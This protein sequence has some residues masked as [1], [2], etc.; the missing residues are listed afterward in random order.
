MECIDIK[1]RDEAP[2][3]IFG[4]GSLVE[5][6]SRRRTT[7]A[8]RDAWPVRVQGVGRGW[9]ARDDS[10]LTTTY[11]GAIDD[12]ASRCNGVIYRVSPVALAATD[13]AD[14]PKVERFRE[15]VSREWYPRHHLDDI[16]CFSGEI[17]AGDFGWDRDAFD[18]LQAEN[19][20]KHGVNPGNMSSFEEGLDLVK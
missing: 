20:T 8:A 1:V 15:W 16:P 17:V 6:E 14:V 4:Y 12:A 3:Y 11:L 19:C 9:W 10:G 5:D 13:P 7:P 18:D 2:I